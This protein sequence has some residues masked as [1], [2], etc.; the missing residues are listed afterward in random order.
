LPT[1][2]IEDLGIIFRNCEHLASMVDDVL[3]LSQAESGQLV[4]HRE[5]TDLAEVISEA[6]AVV[7]PLIQKKGLRLDIETGAL[8]AVYCD[9]TRIRQVVLNLLSNAARFTE[10][11]GIT[12]RGTAED[13]RVT[14]SIQDTGP[15]IAPQDRTRI[16]EPFCQGSQPLWRDRSGSGLG[17]SISKQFVE[18]HGGRIWLESE[19][20]VGTTFRFE[21]P[22]AQSLEPSGSYSRWLSEAWIWLERDRRPAA[23]PAVQAQPRILLHDAGGA[24]QSA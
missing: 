11:G 15:G 21:L 13:G 23:L 8:P 17:L 19:L 7:R 24:L 5:P 1:A 12:L 20:G 4:L 9:R 14:V 2:V 10:A 22:L 18:M 6:A 16:F 3:D